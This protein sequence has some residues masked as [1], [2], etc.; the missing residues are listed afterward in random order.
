MPEIVE[1]NSCN[2]AYTAI[3]RKLVKHPEYIVSP[4]N[5]KTFELTNTIIVVKNPY[6]RLVSNIHRNLCLKYLAGEFLWYERASNKLH[7]ISHYSKYWDKISDDGKT[8]N[9]CYGNK[10]YTLS[11]GTGYSQWTHVKNELI[12]DKNSRRALMIILSG[13]DCRSDTKDMPC[14]VG[15]QFLIRNNQ[16]H[17]TVWMRSNDIYLGFC[18]DAAI[19]TLWQEKLIVELTQYYP[20]LSMG[21]YTHI[22]TSMHVYESNYE[23]I[24]KAACS[25]KEKVT[26]R[27]FNI[28][29]MKSIKA[30]GEVQKIE[31]K[32]R[33]GEVIDI[34]SCKIND[35]FGQWL[36]QSLFYE[37]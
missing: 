14:T 11:E 2:E 33:Q 18:Y 23:Q 13:E 35:Q 31:H 37:C 25:P 28:P 15:I 8:A 17:M 26:H 9:S 7:E 30:I 22:A 3:A 1:V 36:L 16:L 19:F 12:K 21:T 32:I 29:K 27:L 24:Q 6:D 4:R 5:Y 10:I 20:D 34:D